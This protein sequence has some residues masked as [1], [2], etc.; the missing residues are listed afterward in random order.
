MSKAKGFLLAAATAAMAFILSCS[1]GG[2]NIEAEDNLGNPGINQEVPSSS[3]E[4]A[5]GPSSSSSF[6]SSSE[7]KLSSSSIVP[8]SSSGYD[9]I[10]EPS[11]SSLSF[12]YSSGSD[13]TSSSSEGIPPNPIYSIWAFAIFSNITV[14][15]AGNLTGVTGYYIYRSTTADGTYSQI[16]YSETTSYIDYSIS[17]GTTYYYKV[18]A[19]VL[20]NGYERESSL[21]NFA[22]ATTES[23]SS[24]SETYSSSSI[25]SSSSSVGYSGSYGSVYY[26]GQSYKTVVIGTQTWMAENLNYNASGS[27]CYGEDSQAYDYDTENYVTLSYSEIQANCTTYGRLY[28][29]ATAMALPS[30]CNSNTCSNQ[31]QSKHQGVCPS[32]WHI[33]TND[34]WNKLYRYI[35]G[36]SGTESLYHSETAGR[37]LKAT[38]GWNSYSGWNSNGTDLYGFSALPGGYRLDHNS[39]FIFSDIG[40]SGYWWSASEN[41][42]NN[43]VILW[44]YINEYA[45]HAV[46]PKR[47]LYS[48]RCLQD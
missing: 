7:Y 3:S 29:W 28:D 39:N 48:V 24:S 21:S 34:E 36:T 13:V 26:G 1:L 37:Y 35:D 15:W 45:Y 27:K 10:W 12:G 20:T 30:D 44:M 40:Y 11:S 23:S 6:S 38:S 18:S 16:G 19:Y 43:V 4:Y 41:T 5:W 2:S 46:N 42:Y 9:I 33:P 32:G 22:Y 31:I 8:S 14:S 25:S 17:P 47:Y